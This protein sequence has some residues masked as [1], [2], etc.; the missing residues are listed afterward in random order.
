MRVTAQRAALPPALAPLTRACGRW[1]G[2]AATVVRRIPFTLCLLAT[3]WLLAALTDSL[4]HGVP[5]VINSRFGYAPTDLVNGQAY[6]VVTSVLFIHKRF[7]IGPLNL[8]LL[9]FILPYEWIAGTRRAF[10]V[11]WGAHILEAVISGA[12]VLLLAGA[13]YL[14]ASRLSSLHDVGMSAGTFACAGALLTVLPRRWARIGGAALATYLLGML[15][16]HHQMYD[17]DHCLVTPIGFAIGALAGRPI[18][19]SLRRDT[20]SN[21][22]EWYTTSPNRCPEEGGGNPAKHR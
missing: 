20:R 1:A 12:A 18:A 4:G 10:A 3:V 13:G 6:T 5:D 17:L 19:R 15:A 22:G 7:M 14:P 8:S 2:G 21:A 9:L 16:F 11:F